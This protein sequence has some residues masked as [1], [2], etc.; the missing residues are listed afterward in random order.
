MPLVHMK[1]MSAHAC[2]SGYAVGAFALVSM[3]FLE[4][5]VSAAV[6]LSLAESYFDY[7]GSERA[8]TPP[9]PLQVRLSES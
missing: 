9:A 6:I 1:D 5:I 4:T 2:D 7:F 8:S 3:D